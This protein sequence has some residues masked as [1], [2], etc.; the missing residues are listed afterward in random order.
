MIRSLGVAGVWLGA[1][2][3]QG[4]TTPESNQQGCGAPQV[5]PSDAG[6][7]EAGTVAPPADAGESHDAGDVVGGSSG[8]IALGNP[9]VAVDGKWTT[10]PFP[11]AYCRNGTKAH[12]DVH[13]NSKSN[14]FAIYLEG[15]GGCFTDS[16]CQSTIDLSSYFFLPTGIWDF[17]RA[18]NPI[19][20]WNIF[21]IP[22]CEGDFHAGDNNGDPGPS[23]GPQRYSGYT[24]LKLYLSRIL[25]TV[26]GATDELLMGLSAGGFGATTATDLVARNMPATVERFTLLNDAGL[27]FTNKA[28]P[29]CMQDRWRTVWGLDKT[30]LK[31]C[32]TGCPNQNDYLSDWL[33]FIIGK[34]GT[35]PNASKFMAGFI[36]SNDD[37][38]SEKAAGY[39][40]SDCTANVQLTK[41]EFQA[42]LTDVREVTT[43]LTDRFGTFYYPTTNG[44][45]GAVV[46][47][48]DSKASDGTKLIDWMNALLA[49]TKAG[50]V[51]P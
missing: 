46:S 48:L 13:L 30:F 27:P 40:A 22:N 5:T 19:R 20:D 45:H 37:Y 41:S 9:I 1:S 34:Y 29:A 17:S 51:G 44:Q 38:T 4:A 35:G 3:L 50:T 11:D 47:G 7:S 24:N 49:H 2:F 23:T 14:K 36:S 39:G 43:R 21:W 15:G 12:V 28:I 33:K 26:P 42:A 18:D 10:I 6:A 16:S 31:D 8:D 32:G 25:A